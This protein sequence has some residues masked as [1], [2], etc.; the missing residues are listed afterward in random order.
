MER[1]SHISDW[2]SCVLNQ[3]PC[4]AV[5]ILND[6]FDRTFCTVSTVPAKMSTAILARQVFCP[7]PAGEVDLQTS[8]PALAP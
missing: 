8:F 3:I 1:R 5:I 2:Q 4:D 6:L 7:L